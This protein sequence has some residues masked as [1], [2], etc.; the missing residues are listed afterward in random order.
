M[1]I[2]QRKKM[3]AMVSK[4][5]RSGLIRGLDQ[6]YCGRMVV[7]GAAGWTIE[8]TRKIWELLTE[9]GKRHDLRRYDIDLSQ[10]PEPPRAPPPITNAP[11]PEK[12][13]SH[14]ERVI[15]INDDREFEV[16]FPYDPALVQGIKQIPRQARKYLKKS[17]KWVV[18][19]RKNDW[20]DVASF[21]ALYQ[22]GEINRFTWTEDAQREIRII[23]EEVVRQIEKQNRAQ[24]SS[25]AVDAEIEIKG[26]GGVLMPFQKAGVAYAMK[27]KRT[28]I[29]DQMGLGKRLALGTKVLT[30][31]GW[32]KIE[33]IKIGQHVVGSDGKPY[34]V[35]GVFRQEDRPLFKIKFS[36]GVVINAD[37]EHL[38]KIQHVRNDFQKRH[39]TTEDGKWRVITTKQILEYGIRDNAG[40]SNWR[41]PLVKPVSHT[42]KK[43]LDDPYL[44]GVCLGDGAAGRNGRWAVCTDLEILDSIG[45]TQI[46]NHKTSPYTGYG[47]VWT[48]TLSPEI[49][50]DKFI[51]EDYFFGSIDQRKSLL[52]GLLDTDGWVNPSGTVQFCSTSIH[53]AR[54][55]VEL[56][57]SLG[58]TATVNKKPY[59]KY[60]VKGEIRIGKPAYV[61]TIRL[62]FN[63]FILTRKSNS[64]Q[65]LTKYKPTRIISAI[66][67]IE[68]GPGVCLSVESP[69]R[70]FVI[71][72]HVVTHNTVQGLATAKAV[73]GFPMLIVTK[74][75]LK[76]NWIREC[77][78]WLPRHYATQ[79]PRD[80]KQSL[81]KILVI[82]YDVL[83][84]WEEILQDIDWKMVVLD[85]SQS[86]KN[87]SAKR[88]KA[89][90]D[91]M[92]VAKPEYRLCLTGTPIK[93]RPKEFMSQLVILD[94][95]H[96]FGGEWGYLN[97]Y[98]V[99]L[100][101]PGFDGAS[102]LPELNRKLR[103]SCYIR[104]LKKDVL[105]ELPDKRQVV[106]QFEIDNMVEYRRAEQ[107]VASFLAAGKTGDQADKTREAAK[108]HEQIMKLSVLRK[109]AAE[110]TV[111]AVKEWVWDLIEQDQKLIIFAHHI[112]IQKMCCKMY[113][114]IT[115][116]TR[117]EK[118]AQWAVDEFQNN[119]QAKIIVCSLEADKD[120]HTLTAASNVLFVEEPWTP[121]D[122][123]QATDRAHRI[124]Q[125]DSVTAYFALAKGTIAEDIHELIE[126]KRTVVD[127]ATEGGEQKQKASMVREIIDRL[128]KRVA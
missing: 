94:R 61:V 32:V 62:D 12:V 60:K 39:P 65:P 64:W 40:N 11:K 69:D 106:L 35:S 87:K 42:K 2:E 116:T 75:S 91:L 84:K 97:R 19:S 117:T 63:P 41:I 105:P 54:G 103:E 121:S 16:T 85:E 127:A 102:Y 111:K 66:E 5:M 57:Q 89:L 70:L 10:L 124:G 73:N 110:G 99:D 71:E 120:G 24:E 122:V 33:D 49:S 112:A 13:V 28:F 43:L 21:Q 113:P 68:N 27:A 53:L 50:D 67:R 81:P 8:S 86:V 17:N 36:D 31:F 115:V 20:I 45:A 3:C 90:I 114:E 29:A 128:K 83:V 77:Q 74:K 125:K 38:W 80:M 25:T 98:C 9:S 55:V 93:N 47:V 22:F 52:A 44:V 82:N 4:A 58:G 92:K 18:V 108:E 72:N 119:P 88:T 96:E 79:D 7:I 34:P 59:P 107:D 101:K 15:R 6:Q 56:V 76:N 1:D 118:G 14:S 23:R 126:E 104:R 78:K 51:P 100:N 109:I 48:K 26:L 95:I 30:P 37:D 123:D 46:K